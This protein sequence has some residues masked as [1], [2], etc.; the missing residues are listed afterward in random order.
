MRGLF[1]PNFSPVA[2][3]M[4]EEIEVTVGGTDGH[5]TSYAIFP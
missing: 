4:W 2:L 5:R 1:L 3:K